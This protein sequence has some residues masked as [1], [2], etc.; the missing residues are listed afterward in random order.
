MGRSRTDRRRTDKRR[1]WHRGRHQR[2]PLPEVNSGVDDGETTTLLDTDARCTE[3]MR[4]HIK[5]ISSM[6]ITEFSLVI[7]ET[8]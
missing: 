5:N 8:A 3:S 7:K 1:K 4:K 2:K 6:D